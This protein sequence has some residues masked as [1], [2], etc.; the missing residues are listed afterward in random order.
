M[1]IQNAQYAAHNM[2]E[3]AAAQATG[4]ALGKQEKVRIRIPMNPLNEDDM[5]VPVCINGHHYWLERGKSMEVPRTVA[6]ILAEA[7]YI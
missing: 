4:T 6:E 2:Q 3:D 5:V 1:D 7:A